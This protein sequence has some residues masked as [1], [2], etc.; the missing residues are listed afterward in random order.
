MF[1]SE[2]LFRRNYSEASKNSQRNF[3]KSSW[4]LLLVFAKKNLGG[5][6]GAPVSLTRFKKST[7]KRILTTP[8]E[9]FFRR[10]ARR[11]PAETFV[12]IP[13]TNFWK[14]PARNFG[15]ISWRISRKTPA[16][17]SG[18]KSR[19]NFLDELLEDFPHVHLNNS[20][21]LEE[22]SWICIQ[23]G[24]EW[25]FWKNNPRETSE[26]VSDYLNELQSELLE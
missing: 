20:R 4:R 13:S 21:I 5:I 15:R 1:C 12:R 9:D 3:S 11:S 14:V 26:R 6:S 18:K 25:V 17:S 24:S 8:F 22:T 7:S 23:G 16:G 10:T 2:V 19:R